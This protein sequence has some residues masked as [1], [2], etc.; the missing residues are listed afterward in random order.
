MLVIL[1]VIPGCSDTDPPSQGFQY[2]EV[3][4]RPYPDSEQ[5]DEAMPVTAAKLESA[6]EDNAPLSL[7]PPPVQVEPLDAVGKA[8]AT[9]PPPSTGDIEQAHAAGAR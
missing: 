5:Q 3:H 8:G 4:M 6:T 7:L 1:A 2:E 9:E